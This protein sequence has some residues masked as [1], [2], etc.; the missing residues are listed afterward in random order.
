MDYKLSDRDFLDT[1]KKGFAKL[2]I[3]HVRASLL[4]KYSLQLWAYAL[5]LQKSLG[6]SVDHLYILQFSPQRDNFYLHLAVERRQEVEAM[7][8]LSM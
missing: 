6:V 7:I 3:S 5:L 2:P 4:E 1:A 8:R